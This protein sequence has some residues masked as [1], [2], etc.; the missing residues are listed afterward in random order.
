V[1]TGHVRWANG[2]TVNCAN[3]R[4]WWTVKSAQCRS[5]KSELRSQ[6]TPNCPVCQRTV[7]CSKRTKDFNGQMLQTPTVYWRGRHRLVNSVMFGAPLDCPVCPSTATAGI[8]VG[9]INT[10]QPPP[11]KPSKFYELHIQYKS[12]S[13]HSK[14]HSKDQI[15]SKPQIQLN[16]LM[17][18]ERVFCV[19]LLL[20][21][22]GLLYSSDSKL[23]KC[24]VKLARD[25]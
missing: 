18:W 1:C 15:L 5:Q 10:P 8:V 12:K 21:L 7:R 9:A 13:I 23:I 25:T 20:L 22:L 4:L 17:T 11:F 2:A 16:C 24:F 14:T 3:G 6:N 19:S